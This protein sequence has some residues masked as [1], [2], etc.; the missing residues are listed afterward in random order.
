MYCFKTASLTIESGEEIAWTL[1][2]E[3]GGN[4]TKVELSNKQQ[5]VDIIVKEQC[6]KTI[7]G[8]FSHG[9]FVPAVQI[10]KLQKYITSAQDICILCFF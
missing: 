5:A 6:E 2:G 8:S 4:H 3:Y 7:Y 1:D 10:C 9:K